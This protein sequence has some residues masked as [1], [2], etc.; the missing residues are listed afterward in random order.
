MSRQ[1][2]NSIEEF[3]QAVYAAA[4]KAKSIGDICKGHCSGSVKGKVRTSDGEGFTLH[5]T[6]T[7]LSSVSQDYL[8][9]HTTIQK[10]SASPYA[11]S[12][13]D[14]R[15]NIS[16]TETI[17]NVNWSYSKYEVHTQHSTSF[18]VDGSGEY[19][20]ATLSGSYNQQ[21]GKQTD[22][23]DENSVY[24]EETMTI[25]IGPDAGV[26]DFYVNNYI[27]S[28]SV[29]LDVDY[30]FDTINVKAVCTYKDK[31]TGMPFKGGAKEHYNVTMRIVDLGI[32]PNITV[33]TSVLFNVNYKDEW[34][35][36]EIENK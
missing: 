34:P 23:I 2:W 4:L 35:S 8:N 21:N 19:D 14:C 6:A 11:P 12:S 9:Q 5:L 13:V 33:S 1:R 10:V 18:G 15:G 32:N 20:G 16:V 7:N 36:W 22:S 28:D 31:N 3:G 29:N 26:V 17:H 27:C 24:K 30:D 25:T